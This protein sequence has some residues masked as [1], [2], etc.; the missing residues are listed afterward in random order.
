MLRLAEQAGEV[1]EL[2]IGAEYE[3]LDGSGERWAYLAS[4]WERR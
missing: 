1:T 4:G 3:A 2:P